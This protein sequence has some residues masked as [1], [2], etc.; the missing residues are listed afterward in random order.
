MFRKTLILAIASLACM[1]AN[2][3]A[4]TTVPGP[5][6][7]VSWT[8]P[9]NNTN[10]TPIA[11]AITYN[12]YQGPQAGTLVKVQSGITGTS[13]VITA[14]IVP[15]TVYCFAATAV[16]NGNES[17]QTSPACGVVAI[18]TPNAPG[19]ITIIIH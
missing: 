2:A 1:V 8:A 3:Q 16:A 14:G 4:V 11:G 5:T 17:V 15:G 7:A 6:I 13:G 10:G 9:T 12:L 18:G 19:Q